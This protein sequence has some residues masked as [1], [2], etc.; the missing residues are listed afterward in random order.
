MKMSAMV[1]LGQWINSLGPGR[2]LS[3]FSQIPSV[4]APTSAGA[5]DVSADDADSAVIAAPHD[6]ATDAAVAAV[7]ANTTDADT[8]SDAD[9]DA[10]HV[11]DIIQPL[12]TQLSKNQNHV[13]AIREARYESNVD[14]YRGMMVTE[15]FQSSVGVSSFAAATAAVGDITNTDTDAVKDIDRGRM[16]Q[17][18]VQE[19]DIEEEEG[20][21]KQ[22]S[23]DSGVVAQRD[24]VRTTMAM[25]DDDND[26]DVNG[27]SATKS[28]MMATS[29]S[30]QAATTTTMNTMSTAT[31][32]PTVTLGRG[33]GQTTL[34]L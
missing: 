2:M 27:A 21:E 32:T 16:N 7:M 13:A 15:N 26:I 10:D 6:A 24:M 3:N 1:S 9:N 12:W 14:L 25:S 11:K 28:M 22:A 4:S 31:T 30:R 8:D 34:T 23:K 20:R 5:G 29:T 18:K 19:E 33:G 17:H